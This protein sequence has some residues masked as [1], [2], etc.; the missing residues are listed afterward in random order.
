LAAQTTLPSDI[1]FKNDGT[2]IWIT[3]E[4]P[5]ANIITYSLSQ[6]WN[7][8][9]I[10]VQ[11]SESLNVSS[12][13]IN[14]R[15]IFWKPDGTTFYIASAAGTL[16]D[17]IIQ[18][19]AN[20]TWNVAAATLTDRITIASQETNISGITFSD[21]GTKLFMV[22]TTNNRLNYYRLSIPWRISSAT[23]IR[24]FVLPGTTTGINYQSSVNKLYITLDTGFAA[25]TNKVLQY[26]YD[27]NDDIQRITSIDDYF[28]I[29]TQNTFNYTS[30]NVYIDKVF[31]DSKRVLNVNTTTIL[32]DT[33]FSTNTRFASVSVRKAK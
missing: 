26:A 33:R 4:T 10:S 1:F 7:V 30:N 12:V 21:D 27:F 17:T 28:T 9:T 25:N 23:F 13:S 20:Q 6:P 8:Q 22:G 18:Y 24:S 29:T 15:S 11:T 2:K 32:V 16:N 5:T 14:P 31:S 3:S 19:T